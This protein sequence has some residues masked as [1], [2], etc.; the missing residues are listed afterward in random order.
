MRR[1]R[2]KTA[3]IPAECKYLF[4]S[5]TTKKICGYS[6]LSAFSAGNISVFKSQKFFT[7]MDILL[8]R[9]L[10]SLHEIFTFPSSGMKKTSSPA[11]AAL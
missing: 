5:N 4:L 8:F 2:R 11:F 6:A 7:V 3:E 1:I 10:S 9:P